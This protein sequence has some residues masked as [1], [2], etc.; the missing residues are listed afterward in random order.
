[1]KF[2]DLE[3][4]VSRGGPTSL[5]S[6]FTTPSTAH[7]KA[8]FTP[9]REAR[10]SSGREAS[11]GSASNQ[12]R[13]ANECYT[14]GSKTHFAR[15]CPH[16]GKG[17]PS[18][19]PGKSQGPNRPAV[20]KLA[21]DRAGPDSAGHGPERVA[22]LRRQLEEAELQEALSRRSA[23]MHGIRSEEASGSAQ[24]GPTLMADVELEGSQT[25]ALLD[26]G[27]PV[28]IV[29]L[30]FL[31]DALAKQRPESQSPEDWKAAV[32]KCLEPSKISLHDYGGQRLGIVRQVKV[33]IARP[34]CAVEAVVQVQNR[35]P[36]D[37]LIGTDLLPQLG[38]IFLQTELNG[39]DLDLLQLGE[40]RTPEDRITQ[41]SDHVPSHP[42]A[43]G[44][45]RQSNP[46]AFFFQAWYASS[47]RH[48]YQ[49]ST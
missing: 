3:E 10:G 42:I 18:E 14:C 41:K 30:Q 17:R 49:P 24:L 44:E 8:G 5:R 38:F 9:N 46:E 15:Q 39:E 33:R 43:D 7:S 22:E 37:L 20:A 40:K 29:S 47:K 48:V 36:I 32:E 25:K 4:P 13:P 31:L 6:S 26:T 16:R 12:S 23:T 11:H 28:T 19:T 45:D 27:S 1:M 34:G 21:S 2:R 35:A